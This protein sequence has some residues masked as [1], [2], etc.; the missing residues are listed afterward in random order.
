MKAYVRQSTQEDIDYLCNNL[1]PE[2]RKEVIASHGSTKKALQI[3]LDLSDECWTFLV[4]DTNEIAG[5]YGVAKQ[6]DTV[7]C[8]WLLTTP[9][10]TKIW[11]TFLRESK[12]LTK[13][14]NKKYTILTNS[15]DAEYTTAIK[16]LKFLGFT[17]INKHNNWGKTFLE[18]VRI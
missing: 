3:G 11:I 9:A 4:E 13:E 16:W 5:I 7:A 8:V 6:C 2:D 10:V 15:V 1:R 17:F 14:M 12:R 18:F